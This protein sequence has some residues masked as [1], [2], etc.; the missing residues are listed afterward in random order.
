[1]C[2]HVTLDTLICISTIILN[3][4]VAWLFNPSYFLDVFRYFLLARTNAD[5][6]CPA[7]KAFTGF[8]VEADT[9]GIQIGR[10]V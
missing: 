7:S 3:I 8:I 1:M 9:P 10:K 4:S 2:T 5:P 6:K